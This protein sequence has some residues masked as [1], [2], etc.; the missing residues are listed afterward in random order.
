MYNK[1]I[2]T[3]RTKLAR[4][5]LMQY[6]YRTALYS[7]ILGVV[8]ITPKREIAELL[9]RARN[10]LTYKV[11]KKCHASNERCIY[12]LKTDDNEISIRKP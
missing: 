5:R 9:R 7:N 11:C 3:A 4:T 10:V 1:F 8:V 2:T 12:C 6:N